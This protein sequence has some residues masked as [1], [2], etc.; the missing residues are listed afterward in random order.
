MLAMPGKRAALALP[1]LVGM[2][3]LRFAIAPIGDAIA[4]A[5]GR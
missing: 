2:V 3:M 5:L 1:F 4:A